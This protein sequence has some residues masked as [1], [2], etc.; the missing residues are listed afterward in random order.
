[1]RRRIIAICFIVVL[2]VVVTASVALANWYAGYEDYNLY[3]AWATIWTPSSSPYTDPPDVISGQANWVSTAGPYWVQ[4]GWL[5][6][7]GDTIPTRYWEYCAQ[8]CDTNPAQYRLQ[9]LSSQ[10]WNSGIKYSVEYDGAQSSQT[11]CA[12]IAGIREMCKNDVRT[13]PSTMQI[14]TEVQ[15]S[16]NNHIDTTFTGIRIHPTASGAWTYP[17]LDSYLTADS[18]YAAAK[19]TSEQFNTRCQVL[20]GFHLAIRRAGNDVLLDW[21]VSQPPYEVHTSTSDPY[22][23]P[24]SGTLISSPSA[25]RYQHVGALGNPGVGHFYVVR[26]GSTVSKRVGEFEYTLVPGN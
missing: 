9:K 3:G 16:S 14:Q 22:F 25:N 24:W 26:T 21:C 7:H 20:S 8:N 10:N 5:Y 15:H 12:W 6:D 18:P 4:T 2:C 1:M 17:N 19:V 23:W 11:W 13:A